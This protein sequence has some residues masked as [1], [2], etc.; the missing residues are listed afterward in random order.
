M[1]FGTSLILGLE[2]FMNTVKIL[3][4]SDFHFDTPFKEYEK[5]MA[6]KR[7][8]ELRETFANIVKMAKNEKVQLILISGDVFDNSTVTYETISSMK[9][10]FE[11]VKHIRIFI[12]AGNHDPLSSNSY[13]NSVTWPD[14]V[15]IFATD[16]EKIELEELGVCVYGRSF[17]SNYERE[18]FLKNFTIEDLSKI[19]LMVMHGEVVQGISGSD[20]NPITDT[21]IYNSG[22][23][24]LAL[25]HI[26]KFSGIQRNGKTYWSYS[27]CAE[28][29]GFDELGPKGIVIGEIGKDF[30]KLDFQEIC[31]R[32]LHQLEVDISD[33]E[34][35]DDILL[36]INKRLGL[37]DQE[38]DKAEI[39]DNI[40]RD[41]YKII[42]KGEIDEEFIINKSVLEEKLKE[43]F[44]YVKIVDLTEAK[45]DYKALAEESNLKGIFVNKILERI[46]SAESDEDKKKLKLALKMGLEALDYRQVRNHED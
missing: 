34:N 46:N 37:H 8:E 35:Y 39:L 29:R 24:Y 7:K 4:C 36:E 6:E 44:Y 10:Y 31:K 13:Y 28:G 41:I 25:G 15:H 1:P 9:K 12:S 16:M 11:Q 3:H 22:L 19:N 27:G 26:H 14:N 23:D 18:G 33:A 17:S 45:I 40:K 38:G 32:R 43:N 30:A 21:E 5:N 42:L 2:D 20:Y